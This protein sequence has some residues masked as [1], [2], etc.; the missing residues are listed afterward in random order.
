M[1]CRL[2]KMDS[3]NVKQR[4]TCQKKKLLSAGKYSLFESP[5]Q[6]SLVALHFL[7]LALGMGNG[8]FTEN[9]WEM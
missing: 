9:L 5:V 3:S 7:Q 8:R 4:I 1:V 6:Y 2:I